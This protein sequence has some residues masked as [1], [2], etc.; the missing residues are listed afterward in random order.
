M[1]W[2][3]H[4]MEHQDPPVTFSARVQPSGFLAWNGFCPEPSKNSPATQ[5]RD[6]CFVLR[7][8]QPRHCSLSF[9]LVMTED[10]KINKDSLLFFNSSGFWGVSQPQSWCEAKPCHN[11]NKY[12]GVSQ[13]PDLE[14]PREREVC[15]SLCWLE[16]SRRVVRRFQADIISEQTENQS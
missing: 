12:K 3:Q 8:F 11:L 4:N 1:K 14:K 6:L 16:I 2:S 7:H 9:S 10:F 15:L 13:W 5:C